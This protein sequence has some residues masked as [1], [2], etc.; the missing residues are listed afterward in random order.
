MIRRSRSNFEC[1]A[2]RYPPRGKLPRRV[3]SSNRAPS[4]LYELYRS[5]PQS[6]GAIVA[7]VESVS[8]STAKLSDVDDS[9]YYAV[10]CRSCLRNVRLSLVR[11][12]LTL[13]DGYAVAD[14]VKHL[15]CRT[16]RSREVTVTFLAPHQAVGNL[17]PLFQQPAV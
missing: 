15:R 1:P 10:G 3:V 13:G 6:T 9:Y 16:C 4:I 17:W 5:N 2:R 11:L 7:A 8:Y 14:V 12:R